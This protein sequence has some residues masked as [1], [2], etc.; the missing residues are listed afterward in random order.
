M[1]IICEE[2]GKTFRRKTCLSEYNRYPQHFC[3]RRCRGLYMG[4][5]TKVFTKD[6]YINNKLLR[7]A[8]I[9]QQ[10]KALERMFI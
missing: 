3:S 4:K 2:C 1:K 7:L 6:Y 8:E 9:Y 5:H 10:K